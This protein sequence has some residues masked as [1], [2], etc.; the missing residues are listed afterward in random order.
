MAKN[1]VGA[2]A[3]DADFYG[4]E[5]ESTRI[6]QDLDGGNN[7][8]LLGPRR[9][10]KSS[11][12]RHL[13]KTAPSHG[14]IPVEMS[15]AGITEEVQ[16]IQRLYAAIGRHAQ[17]KQIV[18]MVAGG[19]LNKFFQRFRKLGFGP[20]SFELEAS[21]ATHWAELGE[22]LTEALGQRPD[23]KWLFLLDEVSLL[24]QHLLEK[25][26][27]RART[28]LNWLRELR[29]GPRAARQNR[30]FITGSIGLPTITRAVSL[31]DTIND[32]HSPFDHYGPFSQETA[33]SFLKELAKQH[34]LPLADE[35][36]QHILNRV[37]WLIPFHL[38]NVFSRLRGLGQPVTAQSID[39]VMDSLANSGALF[40]FWEER[41]RKHLR[42]PESKCALAI[43]DPIARDPTGATQET[44]SQTLA[45]LIADQDER[46][47]V[48]RFLLDLL[49]ADGYLVHVE[50]RHRF[51]SPLLRE[52]WRRHV[53]HG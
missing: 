45:K 8:L 16:V 1:I 7:V 21:A 27:V 18:K 36:E 13:K 4:R 23:T 12:L 22:S 46:L 3:E 33:R 2:P 34:S 53:N 52:Y 49:I 10:G 14:F 6:W 48:L 11:M 40:S 5:Y 41:V 47:K 38:Q 31:S 9:V 50:G 30:W 28:F 15:L 32:L 44:L 35:M 43:L 24:V 20:V 39:G 19:P 51:L 29:I 17:G 25:D 37:E 26:P 42:Q